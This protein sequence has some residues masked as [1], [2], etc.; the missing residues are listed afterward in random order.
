MSNLYE[1]IENI[2]SWQTVFKA[3]C[4]ERIIKAKKR[5]LTDMTVC[6]ERARAYKKVMEEYP[7]DPKV[8]QR[9]KMFAEYLKTKTIYIL[10]DELIVGNVANGPRATS[11]APEMVAFTEAE[12]DDR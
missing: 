6:L 8:I 9:A 3:N 1:N 7:N 5:V 4:S 12:M 10:E 2:G 11:F